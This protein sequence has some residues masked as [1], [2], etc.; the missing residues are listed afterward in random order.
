MDCGQN[1]DNVLFNPYG[2]DLSS[3]NSH[4]DSKLKVLI[5]RDSLRSNPERICQ[6]LGDILRATSDFESIKNSSGN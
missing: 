5:L 4:L 3:L 2:I 6:I 1:L